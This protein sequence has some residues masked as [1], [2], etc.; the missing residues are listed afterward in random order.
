M[1]HRG[2]ARAAVEEGDFVNEKRQFFSL[3]LSVFAGRLSRLPETG[4][5][6]DS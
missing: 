6:A 3:Q 1:A 5:I 4:L 2:L